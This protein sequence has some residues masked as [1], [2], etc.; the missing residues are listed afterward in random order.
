MIVPPSLYCHVFDNLY[1]V[2]YAK[3]FINIYNKN[4]GYDLE[5]CREKS[6]ELFHILIQKTGTIISICMTMKEKHTMKKR[7][8]SIAAIFLAGWMVGF[9]LLHAGIMIHSLIMVSVIFLLEAVII[10]PKLNQKTKI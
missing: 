9:F 6:L 7:F 3:R 10:T 5:N 4:M 2:F 8:Y 1:L